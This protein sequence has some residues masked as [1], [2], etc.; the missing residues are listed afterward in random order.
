MP[1]CIKGGRDVPG[2]RAIRRCR[3]IQHAKSMAWL[4]LDHL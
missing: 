2:Y 4:S 3:N 1:H